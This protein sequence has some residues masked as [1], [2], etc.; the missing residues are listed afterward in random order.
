MMNIT[1]LPPNVTNPYI[2]AMVTDDVTVVAVLDVSPALVRIYLKILIKGSPYLVVYES[3]RQGNVRRA[4][5]DESGWSDVYTA[6]LQSDGSYRGE[7][8]DTV[9]AMFELP[10]RMAFHAF[11]NLFL[12]GWATSLLNVAEERATEAV[13][14]R[15]ARDVMRA[16]RKNVHTWVKA[17]IREAVHRLT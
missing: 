4:P 10:G 8:A 17:R 6:L 15:L 3:D 14:A 11:K 2:T 16:R 7:S 5:W 9:R 1:T 12:R 13:R